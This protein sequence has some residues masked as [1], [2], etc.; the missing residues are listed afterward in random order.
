MSLLSFLGS[1]SKVQILFFTLRQK[2]FGGAKQVGEDQFGNRYFEGK[3]EK[4]GAK[5][6]RWVLYKNGDDASQVPSLWHG[7][8]HYQTDQLPEDLKDFKKDWEEEHVAN[9]TGT[10]NAYLP[11]GHP[12]KNSKRATATGDYEAWTPSK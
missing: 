3:A 2:L 10:K 9:Q 5:T 7:W 8:L 6:R 11:D 4:S 12:L 1:N